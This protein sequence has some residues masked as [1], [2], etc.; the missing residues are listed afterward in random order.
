MTARGQIFRSVGECVVMAPRVMG[1]EPQANARLPTHFFRER[2]VRKRLTFR[3]LRF[4]ISVN[5]QHST[6]FNSR[7]P[8]S[9]F[10]RNRSLFGMPGSSPTNSA[11]IQIFS[12]CFAAEQSTVTNDLEW[13]VIG[14]L[15]NINVCSRPLPTRRHHSKLFFQ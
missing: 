2:P 6:H 13:K 10:K 5:F 11:L 4:T 3:F 7:C 9:L 14:L 1:G 12:A 15:R 8:S